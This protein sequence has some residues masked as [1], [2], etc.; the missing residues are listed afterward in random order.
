MIIWQFSPSFPDSSPSLA[1][2][3]VRFSILVA[4]DVQVARNERN[5][6]PKDASSQSYFH[7][8]GITW[9]IQVFRVFD[10]P[11]PEID[12]VPYQDDC[13]LS[14]ETKLL[15]KSCIL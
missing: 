7:R 13:L 15:R 3:A 14:R 12:H 9:D 4:I 1:A 2:H 8:V 5:S 6:T 11:N 10:G